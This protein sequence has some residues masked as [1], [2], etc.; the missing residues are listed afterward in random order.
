MAVVP[1][2][3]AHQRAHKNHEQHDVGAR[4][5]GLGHKPYYRIAALRC[6]LLSFRSAED[7]HAAA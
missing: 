4:E 6:L 7:I 3:E 5:E 1:P 2:H